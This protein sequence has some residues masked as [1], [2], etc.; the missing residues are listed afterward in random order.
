MRK[1]SI[2]LASILLFGCGSREADF[3]IS[4]HVVDAQGKPV[5]GRI[6]DLEG[7]KFDPGGTELSLEGKSSC[8]TDA[9]GRC[10]PLRFTTTVVSGGSVQGHATV[11][12][13]D[14]SG[15]VNISYDDMGEDQPTIAK[16]IELQLP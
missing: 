8:T 14:V 3:E 16:T 4:A 9:E 5:S 2:T 10:G 1:L 12:E 11:R 15:Q 13:T 6:V 7:V